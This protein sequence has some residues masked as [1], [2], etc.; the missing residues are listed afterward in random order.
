MRRQTPEYGTGDLVVFGVPVYIGRV[1]NLFRDYF[2][3]IKGNGAIGVPG[4]QQEAAGLKTFAQER[5][6]SSWFR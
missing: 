6:Q 5:E 4:A 3:S 1:P 2:A